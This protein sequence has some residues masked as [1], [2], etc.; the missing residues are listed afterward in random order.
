V[1]Y[2]S[3]RPDGKLIWLQERAMGSFDH[4]GRLVR[5]QGLTMDV[6]ARREFEEA[7]R[8]A[9]RQKDR[10][11]ATLAHE[12]RNPL[13]PIRTAAGMLGLARASA[14]Q[15]E[16]ARKVIQRQVAHMARLLDDLLDVARI[17]RGK[18]ELRMQP[19]RLD[20][21]VETAIEV[22]RPAIDSRR[23]KL[24]VDLPEPSP[25]LQADSVRLSQVVSNLLTN[26]AKYSDPEGVI[27]LRA[28]A[29]QDAVVISVCDTGIGIPP[30]ALEKVFDMFAQVPNAAGRSEGGLGIGLS[31]VK[32]LVELHGGK[33]TAHSAGPGQGSEFTVTLPCAGTPD[34]SG[35]DAEPQG[36]SEAAAIPGSDSRGSRGFPRPQA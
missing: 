10:F 30:D 8:E 11:I 19:V 21:I 32:G 26:A 7:L 6:T 29:A 27:R 18:L 5:L 12:L 34:R 1:G 15:A 13:A 20:A 2:G 14:E 4:G 3:R 9:D 33:I 16:W 36:D 25:V 31:L 35:G 17:T 23:Q 28:T 24:V 22:A